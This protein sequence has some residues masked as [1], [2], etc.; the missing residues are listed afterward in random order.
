MILMINGAFGVGKTT[1]AGLLLEK[2]DNSMIFDPEEVGFMLR[3]I[4]PEEIKHPEEKV[5]DFQA[6]E[7]WRVLTVNVAKALQLKYKK[8]LIIPMTIRHYKYYEYIKNGLKEVDKMC[9]HFCLMASKQ[10]LEKRLIKRGDAEGSWAFQQID[11]CLEN[12]QRYDFGE[13]IDTENIDQ[14]KVVQTILSKIR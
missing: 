5:D 8:H 12:F 9:H 11:G 7:L 1:T 2:I 14:E 4:V 6:M 10:T 3:S 13:Y